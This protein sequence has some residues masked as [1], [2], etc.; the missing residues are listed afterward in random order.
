[1]VFGTAFKA[2]ESIIIL[3]PD[4]YIR[5]IYRENILQPSSN[6]SVIILLCKSYPM[7]APVT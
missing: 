2:E 1:M 3:G 5:E 6:Y 4:R 7:D